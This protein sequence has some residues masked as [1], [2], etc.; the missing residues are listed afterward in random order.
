MATAR[1]LPSGSWRVQLYTGKDPAGRRQYL[2]F[3]APTKKE[4]EFE[5][6]QYQLHYK[7]ISKDA[8]AMTLREATE[9]YIGSKDGVLSP[10]TIR[11]YDAILRNRLQGLMPIRL[12]RLNNSLIQQAINAEAKT[13]SPKYVRNVHGLLSAVLREYYPSF[14]LNVALPQRRISEQKYLE[15]EQ[16]GI[17]LQAI[18][19]DEM[20][21]AV[22]MGLWLGMR[23][24]EITGLT[25]SDV[26]FQKGTIFIHQSKVRGKDGKWVVKD[27]TKNTSSTRS[28]H[29]PNY[30][31]DL[32]RFSKGD[33]APECP[34][35]TMP[36][37][38]FLDRLH[39]IL[40]RNG[41]PLIRFHDLRHC[42]ATIMGALNIPEKYIMARG[43]WS[44][45]AIMQKT[46][47]HVLNSKQRAVD[48]TIDNF[49]QELM[50]G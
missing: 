9:K 30:L 25:W 43:G 42:N 50:D 8:S 17:L 47:Q 5:A 20:E 36:S 39:T 1:Q 41:L 23:A 32:L 10:S 27:T 49:F 13:S 7:E 19:G 48:E 6:L 26:D 24:S 2:S 18:R 38:S 46:Y 29:I 15:P 3:T 21:I 14:H 44:S 35:V 45:S 37:T 31:L 11:G 4:A 40:K 22:L 28:L 16:I 33:A 34:V 12:N